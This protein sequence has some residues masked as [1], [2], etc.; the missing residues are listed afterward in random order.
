MAAQ[1]KDRTLIKEDSSKQTAK[2]SNKDIS[3]LKQ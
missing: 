1:G 3:E 2:T